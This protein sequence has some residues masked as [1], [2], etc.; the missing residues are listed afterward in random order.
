MRSVLTSLLA[1]LVAGFTGEIV[2]VALAIW[3]SATEEYALVFVAT[4]LIA[5]T[6]AIAFLVAQLLG[7]PAAAVNRVAVWMLV[8]LALMLIG[9]V[10]WTLSVPTAQ[11]AWDSDSKIIAGLLLPGLVVVLVQWLIVRWRVGPGAGHAAPR[12]GRGGQ[13]S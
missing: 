7:E 3:T 1:L 13:A 11:R 10:A 5:I 9:L 12:F 8:L 6:A 4:A 2:V